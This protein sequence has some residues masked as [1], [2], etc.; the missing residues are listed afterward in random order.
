MVQPRFD[1]PNFLGCADTI[2]SM[3]RNLTGNPLPPQMHAFRSTARNASIEWRGRKCITYI[4]QIEGKTCVNKER[5][6][7]YAIADSI[8]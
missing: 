2:P 8:E 6:L 4:D 7:H 5:D 1:A 3:E